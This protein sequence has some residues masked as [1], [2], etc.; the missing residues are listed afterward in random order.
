VNHVSDCTFPFPTVLTRRSVL[1]AVAHS[2]LV[3]CSYSSSHYPPL[4][5]IT[6]VLPD[7]YLIPNRYHVFIRPPLRRVYLG[8]RVDNDKAV[9]DD[10]KAKIVCLEA[11]IETLKSGNESAKKKLCLMLDKAKEDARLALDEANKDAQVALYEA[12]KEARLAR[13]KANKDAKLALDK[14]KEDLRFAN[15]SLEECRAENNAL[16]FRWVIHSFLR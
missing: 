1:H 5:S 2:Q 12:K 11:R 16:K 14:A 6:P 13:D 15:L 7:L 8:D 3:P 4:T 10:L 9:I